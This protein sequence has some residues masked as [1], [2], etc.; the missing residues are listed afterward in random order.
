[1]FNYQN[2]YYLLHVNMRRGSI[3]SECVYIQYCTVYGYIVNW[4]NSKLLSNLLGQLFLCVT[5]FCYYFFKEIELVED[6]VCARVFPAFLRFLYCNHIICNQETTL[7]ILILA[8]KYN[9]PSL[10]KVNNIIKATLTI[11]VPLVKKYICNFLLK[12]YHYRFASIT[13]FVT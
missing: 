13:Q 5:S 1:M 4:H 9:V 12:R 11:N 10:R 6:K 3:V 2:V 8:D 7:P